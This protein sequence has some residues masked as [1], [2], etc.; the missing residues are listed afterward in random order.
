MNNKIRDFL[1]S[2]G[3]YFLASVDEGAARVRPM[4][5][6]AVL[7]DGKLYFGMGSEKRCCKQIH[8]APYVEVCGCNADK[9]WLRVR[10]K[11]VFADDPA[12]LE[13]IFAGNEFL[14]KKYA[15]GTGLFFS[16]FYLE[17]MEADLNKMDGS[18]EK[19]L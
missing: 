3:W 10:G 18:C 16:P 17:D 7:S 4:G 5:F 1:K 6:C 8:D 11:A 14:R 19:W 12:V 9:Q 2:C 15:P 13:E